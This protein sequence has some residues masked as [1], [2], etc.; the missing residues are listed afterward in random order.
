[1]IELPLCEG[2]LCTCWMKGEAPRVCSHV[3]MQE[4]VAGQPMFK[5][6]QALEKACEMLGLEIV[7]KSN[8][9]W[10]NRHVGDYPVPKGIK[11]SELGSNADFVIRLNEEKRAE[12]RK[13]Y[14]SQAYEIGMVA[15]PNNPG[16]WVPIYDFYNKGYGLEDVV[17]R[18]LFNDAGEQSVKQLCPILKQRYDMWCD[19]LAAAEVGDNI[20]FMTMKDAT[21]KYPQLFAP[22]SN[23]EQ[24]WVSITDTESRIGVR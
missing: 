10:Y 6:K 23:D 11:V 4:T 17:G 20:Q 2:R 16:C 18:A 19:G 5:D 3:A 21:Q 15:D 14:G 7:E 13:T 8:Y 9:H 12:A 1:M 22:P 24:T